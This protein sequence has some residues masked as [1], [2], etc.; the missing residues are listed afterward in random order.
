MYE[1]AVI[2]EILPSN[3]PSL[4]H[5]FV[6]YV[7][8]W[9]RSWIQA[10]IVCKTVVIGAYICNL[11]SAINRPV[12]EADHSSPPY[13]VQIKNERFIILNCKIST[14]IKIHAQSHKQTEKTAGKIINW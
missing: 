3:F 11:P 12:H 6:G 1:I 14:K 2:H 5:E 8:R 9:K 4:K 7:H 13:S 10:Y